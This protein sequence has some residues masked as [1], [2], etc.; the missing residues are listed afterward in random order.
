MIFIARFYL[1]RCTLY[2]I[3]FMH[4]ALY[5]NLLT[6]NYQNKKT[7]WSQAL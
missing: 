6:G 4:S 3:W 2:M 1:N 5:P 7:G